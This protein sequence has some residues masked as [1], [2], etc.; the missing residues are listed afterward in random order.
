M[1]QIKRGMEQMEQ[2]IPAE[3]D[4]KDNNVLWLQELNRFRKSVKYKELPPEIQNL[5]HANMEDRINQ[6]MPPGPNNTPM[7]PLPPVP[8]PPLGAG[9][10]AFAGLP[11]GAS[12]TAMHD[13]IQGQ[14]AQQPPTGDPSARAGGAPE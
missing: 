14:G 4:E 3:V 2:G 8:P 11:P 12:A 9:G 7:T 10:E 5:F 6:L 13:E 1:A